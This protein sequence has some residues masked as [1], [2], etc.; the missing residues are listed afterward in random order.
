[1]AVMEIVMGVVKRV[2]SNPVQITAGEIW[3][4]TI[5]CL[6]E[7]KPV[8]ASMVTSKTRMGCGGLKLMMGIGNPWSD[9]LYYQCMAAAE[10]PRGMMSLALNIFVDTP[11]AR[12][13]CKEGSGQYMSVVT[14]SICAPKLPVSLL[15]TLY[16]IVN[17]ARGSSSYGH[18]MCSNVIDFVKADISSTLD[19]WFENLFGALDAMTSAV[20]YT[21]IPFQDDA[22]KC[23]DFE[24]DPHVI[25]IVPEPMDYFHRY[26][27]KFLSFLALFQMRLDFFSLQMRGYLAVQADVRCRVGQVHVCQG[28]GHTHARHDH[29]GGEHVLS[30]HARR[31]ADPEKRHGHRRGEQHRRLPDQGRRNAARLRAGRR[32]VEHQRSRGA[33]LVR[34][35][36]AQLD[37]VP[38]PDARVRRE[39]LAGRA[40]LGH[41]W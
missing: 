17:E 32:G 34:P 2:L 20:D 14:S 21:M 16:M 36:D 26:V 19:P 5:N 38:K 37:R 39:Q 7:L 23:M 8:S 40:G 28:P 12:C 4:L 25:V 30:R 41:V 22:G 10:L 11:M 18:L 24:H 15:S 27:L 33:V 29:Q 1:M 6:Y 35:T 13:V 31:H 9:M 3:T